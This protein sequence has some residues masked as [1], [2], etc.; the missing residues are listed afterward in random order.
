MANHTFLLQHPM[1][2]CIGALDSMAEDR[3]EEPNRNSMQ[4]HLH[5]Y[6]FTSIDH[7]YHISLALFKLSINNIN[8]LVSTAM[9]YGLTYIK[10]EEC[11]PYVSESLTQPMPSSSD[12][13]YALYLVLYRSN[14]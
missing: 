11:S 2:K 3:D 10:R 1:S 5:V 7:N 4:I 6:V 12:D 13:I 14:S 8:M 9:L